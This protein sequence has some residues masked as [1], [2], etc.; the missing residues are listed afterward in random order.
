MGLGLLL[1][2][3]QGK[4]NIIVSQNPDI[5]YFKKVYKKRLKFPL[6]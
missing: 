3:S 5:T 4:E 1:L 2:A 6:K